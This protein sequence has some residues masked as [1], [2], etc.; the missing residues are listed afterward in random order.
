MKRLRID[1]IT[2]PIY[3]FVCRS[4]IHVSIFIFIN[5]I[6]I[7]LNVTILFAAYYL[8]IHSENKDL[9]KVQIKSMPILCIHEISSIGKLIRVWIHDELTQLHNIHV[10]CIV[11]RELKY[12][13]IEKKSSFWNLGF[14]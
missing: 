14:K 4:I 12:Y 11:L 13:S 8:K 1:P 10:I 6:Q 3:C 7:C 2:R 5:V 9:I